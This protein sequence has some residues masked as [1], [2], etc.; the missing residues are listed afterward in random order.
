VLDSAAN[1]FCFP[2]K[3]PQN[4][5]LVGSN[6]SDGRRRETGKIF[7]SFAFNKKLFRVRVAV[8]SGS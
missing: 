8:A 3:Y 7:P 5:I 6:N 2:E 4:G 1:A